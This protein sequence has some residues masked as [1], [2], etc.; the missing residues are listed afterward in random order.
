[1]KKYLIIVLLLAVSSLTQSTEVD[2]KLGL[3]V[4][5]NLS[6]DAW[7]DGRDGPTAI[8]PG[9]SIGFET[10]IEEDK[11]LKYGLGIVWHNSANGRDG[12]EGHSTSP[13]YLVGK[14]D[15]RD[16]LYLV[17][18]GGW[19][20]SKAGDATNIEKVDGGLYGGIG[21]GR[22]L[23]DNLSAELMYEVMGYRY[24]TFFGSDE[25]GYTHTEE[26]GCYQIL[27][28]ILSY[29]IWSNN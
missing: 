28:F 22:E 15:L 20:F 7:G 29:K 3:D 10:M 9:A 27:S 4:Y 24:I 17:G 2:F 6:A 8:Y 25:D 21:V 5:R 23:N 18:R 1:M 11:P 14:Y 19:G 16:D 26:E 13:L 12:Y